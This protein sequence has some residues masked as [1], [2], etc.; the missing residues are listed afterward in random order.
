MAFGF[1]Q[2]T[3]VSNKAKRFLKITKAKGSLDTVVVIVQLPI[4]SLRLKPFRFLMRER[5]NAAATR[6]AFFPASVSVMSWPS[7]DSLEAKGDSVL[8]PES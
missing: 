2:L 4:R 1:S 7:D 6:G 3:N 5:R 8:T